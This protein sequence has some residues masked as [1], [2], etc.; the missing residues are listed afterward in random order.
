[1]G[2]TLHRR[3]EDVL[4]E[5]AAPG[6]RIVLLGLD[7]V[8][9]EAWAVLRAAGLELLRVPDAAAALDALIDQRAQIAIA[10]AR[11]GAALIRAARA[12]PDTA[13]AHVVLCARLASEH[14]LRAA[15]DAG[16]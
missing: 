9:Y 4:G 2:A 14:D 7:E 3:P 11:A 10:D 12:R 13:S 16:A 1:M 5:V 8:D 6:E 15:L